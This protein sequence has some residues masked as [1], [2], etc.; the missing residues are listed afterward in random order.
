MR[1]LRGRQSRQA[2]V[3]VNVLKTLAQ[4]VV[5]WTTFLVA[6][7][8]LLDRGER[9]LSWDQWRFPSPALQWFAVAVF[10]LGGTLGLA[11]GI[12]MA[13]AG[14]GTPLPVDCPNHLVIAGPY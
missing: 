8:W 7:P 13:V 6:I 11:S 9:A 5:F 12:V 2:G 3:T 1:H 14:R 4:T 10:A